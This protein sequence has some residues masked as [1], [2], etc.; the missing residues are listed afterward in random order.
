MPPS[1]KTVDV[2][3]I[4]L[5]DKPAATGGV[6]VIAVATVTN[7]W[8][9]AKERYAQV[10]IDIQWTGP[11]V[12]DPP[13]GVDL[14]DGLLYKVYGYPT[15]VAQEAKSLVDALGTTNTTADIPVFY[16]NE[17]WAN[18]RLAGGIAIGDFAVDE[19]EE[20]YIY[21]ILIE[22][23]PNSPWGGYAAAHELTHLLTDT[24]HPTVDTWRLMQGSNLTTTG[25]TGSRRLTA[26]EETSTRGNTH[27]H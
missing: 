13:A 16:V 11:T 14:S 7:F 1:L 4:I 3:I 24:G 9:I 5:R 19:S 15:V 27:A 21:N 17:I 8:N 2:N 18:G 23:S 25:S 10:G 26:S 12:E 6:P 20:N 22:D